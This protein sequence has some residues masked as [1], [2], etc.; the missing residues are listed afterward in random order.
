EEDAAARPATRKIHAGQERRDAARTGDRPCSRRRR[1]SRRDVIA[2]QAD[3]HRGSKIPAGE[4]GTVGPAVIST[5]PLPLVGKVASHRRCDAGGGSL[6]ANSVARD[7]HPHPSPPPQSG[8]GSA[9][10][11]W[12]D[13]T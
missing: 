1:A 8:R 7:E 12:R 6:H 13:P 11:A 5:S 9:V 3:P 2:G 10:P 4:T